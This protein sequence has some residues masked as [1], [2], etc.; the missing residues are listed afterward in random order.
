[1]VTRVTGKN[2]VTIPAKIAEGQGIRRGSMLDWR[3]TDKAHVLEVRVFPDPVTMAEELQGR[4]K[5][6]AEN[7]NSTVQRLI[8][9]RNRDLSEAE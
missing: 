7:V 2:Q 4:G 3:A 9:E 5:K 8:D 6:S 1:M